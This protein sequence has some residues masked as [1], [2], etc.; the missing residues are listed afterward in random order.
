MATMPRFWWG[1]SDKEGVENNRNKDLFQKDL[2]GWD[3]ITYITSMTE[4]HK[5]DIQ[6]KF[7]G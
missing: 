3:K 4:S 2:V 7:K 6:G 5:S 1:T